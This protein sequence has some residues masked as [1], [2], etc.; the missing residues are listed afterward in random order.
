M[1]EPLRRP[2]TTDYARQFR[3]CHMFSPS[4]TSHH[5]R[6]PKGFAEIIFPLKFR[7]FMLCRCVGESK[8]RQAECMHIVS[9][10]NMHVAQRRELNSSLNLLTRTISES[11]SMLVELS[12]RSTAHTLEIAAALGGIRIMRIFISLH[13]KINVVPTRHI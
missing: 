1:I 13:K 12:Y 5:E 7:A 10:W 9:H 6:Q 4:R 3:S 8:A 11:Q 2:S